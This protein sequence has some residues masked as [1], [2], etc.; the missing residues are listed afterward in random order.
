MLLPWKKLDRTLIKRK[1]KLVTG[2]EGK[3]PTKKKDSKKKDETRC[4]IARSRAKHTD[5]AGNMP[6]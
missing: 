1:Q 4:C 3:T 2:R 6:G 5:D